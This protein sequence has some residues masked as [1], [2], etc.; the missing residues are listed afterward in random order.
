MGLGNE[1]VSG[2]ERAVFGPMGR[3]DIDTWVGQ[4][5]RARLG[6]PISGFVFRSGRVAAVYGAVLD[7]GRRVAVK[8]HRGP[9]NVAYLSAA[10]ACQ[11]RLAD[12]GFA[13]G[14]SMGLRPPTT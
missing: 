2:A 1:L 14:H 5:V 13:R 10:I 6:A 8:V 12:A 11:R 7:D 4:H 3:D 9:V